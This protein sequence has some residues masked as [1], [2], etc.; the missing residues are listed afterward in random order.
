MNEHKLLEEMK[1]KL[2]LILYILSFIQIGI[3]QNPFW[4]KDD[5]SLIQELI[6]LYKESPKRILDKFNVEKIISADTEFK[7]LGFDYKLVQTGIG[8][9][10]ISIKSEFYY[11]LDTLIGFTIFPKLP[12]KQRLHKKY[13]KWYSE[14][15]QIDSIVHP[16][17]HNSHIMNEPLSQYRGQISKEELNPK[18]EFFASLNSGL[19]YGLRGGAGNSLLRNRRNFIKLIPTL[20]INQLEY[21]MYSKNPATRLIAIE[22]YLRNKKSLKQLDENWMRTVLRNTGLVET[23]SGCFV[24]REMPKLILDSIVNMKESPYID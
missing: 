19:R 20:S 2:F 4:V 3:S 9:G 23:L 21:F 18:I 24:E 8:G 15:F 11:H 10:Y 12:D 22:Y 1:T 6:K 7:N 13:L 16:L 14:L 17:R 5:K